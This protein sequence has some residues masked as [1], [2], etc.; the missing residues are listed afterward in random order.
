M[1]GGVGIPTQKP[2]DTKGNG[3]PGLSVHRVKP[4][5]LFTNQMPAILT[6]RDRIVSATTPRVAAAQ[7]PKAELQSAQSAV[8]FKR[9]QKIGGT[10]RGEATAVAR[11]GQ[12]REHRRDQD[13]VT[14]NNKTREKEHQ[15]ARIEARSARRNH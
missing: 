9:L 8:R 13:L 4:A 5:R 12:E 11:S 10:G 1:G 14:A 6:R 7:S 2:K 15:G 3:N